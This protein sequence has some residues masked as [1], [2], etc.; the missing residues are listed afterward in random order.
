MAA[1]WELSRALPAE[2]PAARP[3]IHPPARPPARAPTC[4]QL[5][6]LRDQQAD[7]KEQYRKAHER[8]VATFG[9]RGAE[10]KE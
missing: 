3:S 5:N 8:F 9:H 1:R 10:L 2:V 7:A 4:L 6:R